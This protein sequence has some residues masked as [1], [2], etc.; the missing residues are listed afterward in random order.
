MFFNRLLAKRTTRYVGKSF[1]NGIGPL[2]S[3][4]NRVGGPFGPLPLMNWQ[5]V[6]FDGQYADIRLAMFAS[7]WVADLPAFDETA[8]TEARDGGYRLYGKME[9][10]ARCCGKFL[11]S[12]S[13][14]TE[15]E[16][17]AE[18]GQFSGTINMDISASYL[19]LYS[20]TVTWKTSGHPDFAAEPLMQWV[21][22]R[23]SVNIWHMPK[24]KI[25]CILS[26]V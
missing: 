26:A 13:Y 8:D 5:T 22:L 20:A 11:T 3:L 9:I 21:A 15:M 10:T 24:V 17:G 23:T 1:I 18:L 4:G 2:G 12:Y 25:T 6:T 7:S 16:G 19:Y 14:K